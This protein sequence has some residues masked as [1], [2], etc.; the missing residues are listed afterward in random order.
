MRPRRTRLAAA[1][2]LAAM[3]VLAAGGAVRADEGL[4]TVKRIAL[5]DF[6]KEL[7]QDK[8]LVVDVRALETYKAGHIPGAINVPLSTWSEHLERLKASRK[9]IVTYCS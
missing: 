9:P 3:P 1:L 4:A 5:A 6:K 2:A 8:V 7:D